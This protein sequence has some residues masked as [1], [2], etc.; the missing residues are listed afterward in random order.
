M[1]NITGSFIG[2]S[3][4]NGGANGAFYIKT[5]DKGL[6]TNSGDHISD[7]VGISASRC[8]EVYSDSV[9]TVIVDSLVT[10]FYIKF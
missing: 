4:N 10:G 2:G 1:P 8:S 7:T 5:L 6:R 9:N 3:G